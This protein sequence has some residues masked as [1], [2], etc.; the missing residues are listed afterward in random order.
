M[1]EDNWLLLLLIGGAIWVWIRSKTDPGDRPEPRGPAPGGSAPVASPPPRRA[2]QQSQAAGA[3]RGQ[4]RDPAGASIA[5]HRPPA[6]RESSPEPAT[7]RAPHPAGRGNI[8]APALQLKPKRFAFCALDTETTG[9][10]PKS[11]RHRAFE[12]SCVRFT[13]RDGD[14]WARTRLSLFLRVDTRGMAGLKLSPMWQTHRDG[15]GQAQAIAPTEALDALR[16]FVGNLPLVCHNARFDQI[17]I[18]NEIDRTGHPW[19]PANRWICTLKMARMA[20]AGR[21]VGPAPGRPDGMSYRLEDV[22]GA[23]A[24]PLDPAQLHLGHYDA[25]LAGL[26]FLRLHYQRGTPLADP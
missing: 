26:A 16:T 5:R 19:R 20:G 2:P 23:L 24:L 15:G 8:A 22:C 13:P 10:V 9:I 17:V 4:G 14:A 11:R 7:A 21:Y 1:S 18:E 12:I 3:S 6:P 25:E